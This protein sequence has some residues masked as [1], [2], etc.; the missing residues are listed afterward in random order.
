[1]ALLGRGSELRPFLLGQT[2]DEYIRNRYIGPQARER[3]KEKRGEESHNAMGRGPGVFMHRCGQGQFF[4]L[5]YPACRAS[6]S[7]ANVMMFAG[8]M[9]LKPGQPER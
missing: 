3:A 9:A 8:L 7:V 6:D 1:M 5:R 2:E 4:A